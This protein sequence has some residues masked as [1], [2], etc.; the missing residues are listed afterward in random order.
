MNDDRLTAIDF[1]E[2]ARPQFGSARAL[3]VTVVSDRIFVN[4]YSAYVVT[5]DGRYITTQPI[6][7]TQPTIH[8]VTNWRA[9]VGR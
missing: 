1:L 2:A 3:P 8:L 6:A 7:R 4:S 5:T 9:G